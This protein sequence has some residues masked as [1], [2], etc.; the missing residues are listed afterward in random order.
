MSRWKQNNYPVRGSQAPN[1]QTRKLQSSMKTAELQFYCAW[2]L[3]VN[4]SVAFFDY[5]HIASLFYPQ[6]WKMKLVKTQTILWPILNFFK[7]KVIFQN[8][9]Y[10]DHK[11]FF[12]KY[13]LS[14]D[15]VWYGYQRLLKYFFNWIK[16]L[17]PDKR[18]L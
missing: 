15:L 12:K 8:I 18:S 13:S 7:N 5:S 16:K 17:S 3:R 9:H 2:N 4:L 14:L 1:T 10:F 6:S 11:I